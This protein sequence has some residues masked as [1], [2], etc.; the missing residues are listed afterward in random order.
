M[1]EKNAVLSLPAAQALDAADPLAPWRERF[2]HPVTANGERAL[3]FCGNS[4][5]LQ[6]VSAQAKLGEL[7]ADWG[8]LGVAG[9]SI[10]RWAHY[11][12][13]VKAPLAQLVGAL[14]HEVAAANSLTANLSLML[15]SF[16][17]PTRQRRK[18]LVEAM[19]FPSDRYAAASMLR[20]NRFDDKSNL[21][22]LEPRPGEATL[23]TKDIVAL[24]KQADDVALLLLGGV[25][26]YTGQAFELE[27]IIAAARSNGIMVGIDLA[28][29]I[30]NVPME[31]HAWGADFAVWCSYKYLNAGPGAVGGF[32][33]HERHHAD[34]AGRQEGWWGNRAETRFQMRPWFEA[35]QGADAWVLSTPPAPMLALLAAGLEPFEQV[36]LSALRAKSVALTGK[37]YDSLME[38]N[39]PGV[40]V[41]TPE[42]PAQRGAQLSIRTAAGGRAIFDKLSA[43]GVVADWRE[44]DVIRVAPVPLYTSYADV[45]RLIELL[46]KATE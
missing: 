40:Q 46:T 36:G 25:N 27:P 15:A 9:H 26:Y 24:L 11:S 3:Y 16:Y 33:V 8:Q 37:L 7:L 10:G 31:M 35:A 34:S 32:F 45:A 42:D 29:A 14:P 18:I 22:E 4:L 6:P 30:G 44:P 23:R 19:A 28:H 17:R 39:L 20:A 5:G 12:E 2:V 13:Q 38:L 41:I 1:S 21:I 43:Q